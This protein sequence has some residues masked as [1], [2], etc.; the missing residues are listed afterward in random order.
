MAR[1][2]TAR[3]L[4]AKAREFEEARGRLDT[5]LHEVAERTRPANMARRGMQHL[6]AVSVDLL[7]GAAR[8]DSS[9][10]N[11]DQESAE[12]PREAV[13]FGVGAGVV[14]TVGLALWLRRRRLNRR[15]GR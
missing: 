14:V 15:A 12:I 8:L 5:T 10:R 13:L 6:R 3:E 7:E 2:G 11:D 9:A 4:D 1:G